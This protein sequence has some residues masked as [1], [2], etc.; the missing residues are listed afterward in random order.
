MVEKNWERMRVFNAFLLCFKN[1]IVP[2]PLK[3][4]HKKDKKKRGKMPL[5]CYFKKKALMGA[6]P[7]LS[8]VHTLPKRAILSSFQP[9]P[10]KIVRKIG[11][12]KG[13]LTSES[14]S[15]W[16][17]SQNKQM[18]KHSPDYYPPRKK[19]LMSLWKISFIQNTNENISKITALKVQG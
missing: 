6:F 17:K 10:H 13:N 19:M 9:K 1:S 8:T 4:L 14:V 15:L 12:C 3:L 11:D 2:P 7:V 18:P 16:L 5:K